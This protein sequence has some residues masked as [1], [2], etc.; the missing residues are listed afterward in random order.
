MC[1]K[2]C[3]S[4]HDVLAALRCGTVDQHNRLTVIQSVWVQVYSP[5]FADVAD[6]IHNGL[7]DDTLVSCPSTAWCSM[8]RT[9]IHIF[10]HVK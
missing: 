3:A 5:I 4:L 7:Y 9:F 6:D 1:W 2:P 10:V 8:R